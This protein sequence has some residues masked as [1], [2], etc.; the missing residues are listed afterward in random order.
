MM[1]VTL[2]RPDLATLIGKIQGAV[3]KKP[4]VPILA[5]ILFEAREGRV[6]VAATDLEVGIHA[7]MEALVEQP[8]ALALPAR[9][10]FQLIRELTTPQ[11]VIESQEE[12]TA[13]IQAGKSRFRLCG[14]DK[15]GFPALSDLSQAH[16]FVLDG[17]V[18]RRMLS[19]SSFAAPREDSRK[20]LNGVLMRLVGQE[21]IFIGADG[22]RLA[23]LTTPIQ[24]ANP[25]DHDYVISLKA[26]EEIIKLL[27]QDMPVTLRL[28]PDKIGV[29]T[30]S[31]SL[32]AQLLA[33]TF[34]DM[35][36]IPAE[37]ALSIKLHKE[38]LMALLKQIALFMPSRSPS[39]H[40]TFKQNELLL[41]ST[42]SDIGEGQVSMPIDYHGDPFEI[43]FNPL[44]FH[45]ILRHCREEVIALALTDAY[46]PGLITDTADAKFV[47]MPMRLQSPVA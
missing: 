8:G 1:K 32:V 33:G 20:I 43:A 45:D 3:S 10:F 44:F 4:K 25:V 47:L 15:S 39:V 23:K 30:L 42:S 46:S 13:V 22:K 29:E 16:A 11:I 34:P 9:C 27:D 21:A 2:S 7:E 31:A 40:F 41:H 37:T 35:N 5:N 19:H 38:E 12:E 18:L 36:I 24:R 28:T 17:A 6:L 26:V 14:M